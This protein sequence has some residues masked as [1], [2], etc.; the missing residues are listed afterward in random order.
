MS[1]KELPTELQDLYAQ[2][3]DKQQ[4]KVLDVVLE[5]EIPM[6]AAIRQIADE[7]EAEKKAEKTGKPVNESTQ[8]PANGVKLDA[9]WVVTE[10][11]HIDREYFAQM[12]ADFLSVHGQMDDST[13]LILSRYVSS[14]KGH[15][16]QTDYYGKNIHYRKVKRV[17]Q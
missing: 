14:S 15:G 5:Q 8:K 9:G 2:M 3:S 6:E 17:E 12:V 11:I 16:F 13:K 1:F 10:E 7:I 4:S